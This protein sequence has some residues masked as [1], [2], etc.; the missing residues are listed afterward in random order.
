MAKRDEE[1]PLEATVEFNEQREYLARY[2]PANGYFYDWVVS[3]MAEL[4]GRSSQFAYATRVCL[5]QRILDRNNPE[6]I[7]ASQKAF[8]RVVRNLFPYD[9]IDKKIS[10]NVAKCIGKY[11]AKNSAFRC[12]DDEHLKAPELI[13]LR[14]RILTT[15]IVGYAISLIKILGE[16]L[17]EEKMPEYLTFAD[18]ILTACKDD[19][20]ELQ[21]L[22]AV[23][24]FD[25]PEDEFGGVSDH[26]VQ[27][28]GT[29][30]RRRELPKDMEPEFIFQ[31]INKF[32]VIIRGRLQTILIKAKEIRAIILRQKEQYEKQ[33]TELNVMAT[34]LQSLINTDTD[35]GEIAVS[36]ATFADKLNDKFRLDR[37]LSGVILNDLTKEHTMYMNGFI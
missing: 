35:W 15:A 17:D 28:Q 32:I 33:I 19:K 2:L 13:T 31:Q 30:K 22:R 20:A 37:Y 4:Q 25:F 3:M 26:A 18:D 14:Y 8:L 24:F 34:T 29:L 12:L 7:M 10:A 23:Y 21:R 5:A 27:L 11:N 16:N 36:T 9:K 6:H 1:L